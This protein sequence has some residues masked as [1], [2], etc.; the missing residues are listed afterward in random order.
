MRYNFFGIA[1]WFLSF[2]V[3]CG[4]N[5]S[6]SEDDNG[7]VEEFQDWQ[8]R[9]DAF[10]AGVRT[11]AQ[12][13]ITMAKNKYGSAWEKHCNWRAYLNYKL[14]PDF[15]HTS[16]DSVFVQILRRGNETGKSPFVNDSVRMF[17]R[18]YLIPSEKHPDGL[19]FLYSG[20]SSLEK[21]VF[22]MQTGVPSTK[23]ASSFPAGVTTALLY[24][25]VGDF[26]RIYVPSN[27]GYGTEDSGSVPA[28]S[29]LIFDIQLLA[30]FRNGTSV[31]P[32][33]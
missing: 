27:A 31:S 5:A 17:Y 16:H 3:V 25:H 21:D 32:W 7:E 30:F 9:N 6:C 26:C 13:S 23:K 20:Q 28:Y 29:T 1:L 10:V 14:D 2:T 12:D 15:A 11:L 22:N 4:L 8:E 18:A 24:M 33:N 19:V